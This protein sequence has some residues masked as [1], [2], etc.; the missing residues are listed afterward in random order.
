MIF[1]IVLMLYGCHILRVK[2]IEVHTKFS[3]TLQQK[4]LQLLRDGY[5]DAYDKKH[6]TYKDFSITM[7]PGGKI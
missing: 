2:F 6:T 3:D 4:I 5:Y 7:L 1:Q